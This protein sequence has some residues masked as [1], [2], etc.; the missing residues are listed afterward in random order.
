MGGVAA[1]KQERSVTL[2]G[3]RLNL[4]IEH[5]DSSKATQS[6]LPCHDT[7]FVSYNKMCNLCHDKIDPADTLDNATQQQ[8][9]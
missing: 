6:W 1:A 2:M 7:F 9:H 4:K 8:H 3:K 5:F